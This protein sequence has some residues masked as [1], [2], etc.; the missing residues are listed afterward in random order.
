MTKDE[1]EYKVRDL[2]QQLKISQENEETHKKASF[3]QSQDI[4]KIQ[5]ERDEIKREHEKL[6]KAYNGLAQIFDEYLFVSQNSLKQLEGLT[7][8]S[9]M[10]EKNVTQKIQNL[11]KGVEDK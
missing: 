6:V 2:E 3:N 5:L 8:A 10:L 9:V 11:N 1:L 7:Q 4:K